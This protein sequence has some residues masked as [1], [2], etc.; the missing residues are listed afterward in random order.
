MPAWVTE[1]RKLRNPLRFK[2]GEENMNYNC[3]N[4]LKWTEAQLKYTY[5][6]PSVT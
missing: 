5:D 6:V 4:I 3:M 2:I 1:K